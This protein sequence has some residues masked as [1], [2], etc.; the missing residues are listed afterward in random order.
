MQRARPASNFLLSLNALALNGTSCSSSRFHEEA[1]HSFR[2]ARLPPRAPIERNSNHRARTRS[3]WG[4][5]RLELLPT[6]LS[7]TTIR[8]HSRSD[9]PVHAKEADVV[10][11][12]GGLHSS[13]RCKDQ[14]LRRI[15]S[16]AR[17]CPTSCRL[18]TPSPSRQPLRHRPTRSNHRH[19]FDCPVRRSSLVM[20]DIREGLVYL[21]AME[22]MTRSEGNRR[23]EK[24]P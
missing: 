13:E 19:P 5:R 21:R 6:P 7:A 8:L 12:P 18:P 17:R 24:A 11:F 20:T 1:P 16:R 4:T 9:H 2:V 3:S 15:A 14:Y 23:N 22:E 10:H